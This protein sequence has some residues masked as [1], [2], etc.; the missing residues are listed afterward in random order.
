MSI[1]SDWPFETVNANGV[2]L[3]EA[4]VV[5]IAGGLV[6]RSM[7]TERML[8]CSPRPGQVRWLP[9]DGDVDSMTLAEMPSI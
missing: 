5:K 4:S 3:P 8:G 1:I 2:A 9:T 7:S 6:S